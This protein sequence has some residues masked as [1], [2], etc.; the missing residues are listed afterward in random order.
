VIEPECWHDA[1]EQLAEP[2]TVL[3]PPRGPVMVPTCVTFAD[4][5]ALVAAHNA[6]IATED[7][8][9]PYIAKLLDLR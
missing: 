2:A 4:A 6:T 5:P 8:K 7:R 1:P 3:T 9:K